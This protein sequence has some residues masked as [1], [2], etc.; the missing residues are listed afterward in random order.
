M[1]EIFQDTILRESDNG[2]LFLMNHPDKGWASY[3]I[4]IKSIE[5]LLE[6]YKVFVGKWTSDEYGPYCKIYKQTGD[7]TPQEELIDVW[8]EAAVK[9]KNLIYRSGY[10]PKNTRTLDK[11]AR[12]DKLIKIVC[13]R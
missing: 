13:D 3:A 9:L 8:K 2:E 11:L 1:I 4:P 5:E 10:S 7:K 12:I 6:N